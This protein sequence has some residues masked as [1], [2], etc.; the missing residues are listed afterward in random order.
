MFK[1]AVGYATKFSN[2]IADVFLKLILKF[3]PSPLET[4]CAI[5]CPRAWGTSSSV[6]TQSVFPNKNNGSLLGGGSGFIGKHLCTYLKHKG[7]A[8]TIISRM[9]GPQ[10]I[11]WQDLQR[12][13]LPHD[14]TAVVNLAGQNVLDIRQRWSE[15]FKQNVW[16]SRINTTTSLAKAIVNAKKTPSAFVLLTGV[17]AYKPSCTEEYDESTQLI[18][19][20]FFSELC[21]EWEKAARLPA[22][23]P[24]RQVSIRSG[25]VLGN[26]GGMIK[27]LY[28]PFFFGLGGP[29]SP[30]SQYLPWIH[31]HDLIRLVTYCIEHSHAQGV[32]NGVAPEAV[33]NEQ[34]SSVI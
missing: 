2:M 15:G 29:V 8:V 18:P 24:C 3:L 14:A 28:L 21:M 30:G 4:S 5:R 27:Q 1:A 19:F 10:R 33:T 9:P 12:Q 17:G 16:N 11:S 25:V 32:L 31:I 34:F 13:G 26:D 6:S 23:L 20:D 22:S 7:Y